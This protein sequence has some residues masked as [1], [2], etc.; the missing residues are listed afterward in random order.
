MSRA[1][2][3]GLTEALTAALSA[4]LAEPFPGLRA[5]ENMT[6]L[7]GGASRETWAFD[8]VTDDGAEPLIL[9]R[10]PGG[11]GDQGLRPD[12][13]AALHQAATD[14]GVPVAGVHHVFSADDV[15][16]DGFVMAQLSGETIARKILRDD[17][18]T[19]A[20]R[21]LPRH[22][23]VALAD[24][25]AVDPD[26]LLDLL[27]RRG[28]LD[29]LAR[30]REIHDSFSEAHPVFEAAF[31]WLYAYVPETEEMTIVHGDFRIGNLMIDAEG[32]VAVLDW[33]LA[34]IGDPMMD[35]SWISVPSWRFGRLDQPVGGFADR[36]TL[37]A[38]YEAASSTAVDPDRV[39]WWE[40]FGTL[41][42][43]IMCQM[44]SHDHLRGE[45][46]SVERAAIGRRVSE[47]E[48][49]LLMYLDG[50]MP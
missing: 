16:G 17:A 34:Q 10:L 14:G 39:R 49:D 40:I 37:F 7:T 1:R 36:E 13:E 48:L 38:A 21:A 26:P 20:R 11:S 22:C 42:W 35:L 4:A 30:Y 31:R 12:Q 46:R 2:A 41:K 8:A 18:Y 47:T 43:G 32:L 28:P 45:V 24:L 25:H 19:L 27:P 3:H 29:E 23:G 44:L 5:I 50:A 33:E 6:R 15:L 9:R